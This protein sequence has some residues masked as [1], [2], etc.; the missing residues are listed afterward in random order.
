MSVIAIITIGI[1]SIWTIIQQVRLI[2]LEADL[3]DMNFII[4][5]LQARAGMRADGIDK[6]R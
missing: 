5:R 6:V 3:Q 1:L 4:K 2:R